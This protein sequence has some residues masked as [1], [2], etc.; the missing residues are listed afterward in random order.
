MYPLRSAA[1]S[2]VDG[3]AGRGGAGAVVRSRRRTQAAGGKGRTA[4]SRARS[5]RF[6]LLCPKSPLAWLNGVGQKPSAVDPTAG[7]ISLVFRA[8][9]LPCALRLGEII[10]TMRPLACERSP[11]P[12]SWCWASR[13][14]A[15][16]PRL[17]RGPLCRG[18]DRAGPVAWRWPVLAAGMPAPAFDELDGHVR[19][20]LSAIVAERHEGTGSLRGMVELPGGTRPIV[21][22]PAARTAVHRTYRTH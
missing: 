20:P 4:Q 19:V 22:V 21:E 6:S 13:S 17:C 2:V 11:G 8:E 1:V 18:P 12:R 15:A 14:C 10:D 7:V 3:Q 16:S 9:T 5:V